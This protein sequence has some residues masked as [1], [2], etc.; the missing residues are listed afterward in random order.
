MEDLRIIPIP[1][2]P[3]GLINSFLV[4]TPR[5]AM[6]V[7]TG[8]PRSTGTVI[9]A[10]RRHGVQ[11]R[12]LRLIVVTHA[13]VDHAGGAA[14]L[15]RLSG[16]PLLAHRGDLPFF[17]RMRPMGFC[18]T[19][20]FGRLFLRTGL[21]HEPFPAFVP[22]ILL[23]PGEAISL[24]PF[25][26]PGK[27]CSTPGHTAGSLAIELAGGEVIAGD[28]AASGLLLGG[29]AWRSRPKRPPFED[30]PQEVA[31]AL[32]GLL[33]R[34][35]LRFYLGHGGPLEAAGVRRHVA[36]LRR[37]GHPLSHA[38]ADGT[39]KRWPIPCTPPAGR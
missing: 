17:T 19:G 14:E 10:C 24:A 33:A 5:A 2:L 4:L 7:D 39:M 13:H 16:A 9:A 37:C 23:G 28:L 8:L 36:G 20:W 31:E 34:G 3:F 32:E 35:G 38:H 27:A 11:P 26:V 29:I 1:I 25:G 12:D 21:M 22:D 30:D 18:P 6:L 15:R